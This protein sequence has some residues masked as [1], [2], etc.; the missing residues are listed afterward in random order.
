MLIPAAL[1]CVSSAFAGDTWDGGESDPASFRSPCGNTLTVRPALNYGGTTALYH[2]NASV[3]LTVQSATNMPSVLKVEGGVGHRYNGKAETDF[4]LRTEL[5]AP[6][7]AETTF[8]MAVPYVFESAIYDGNFAFSDESGDSEEE[9]A[10]R[11]S[12]SLFRY[13]VIS[14]HHNSTSTQQ[15]RLYNCAMTIAF[16]GSNTAQRVCRIERENYET[17]MHRRYNP[18]WKHPHS[19]N[20]NDSRRTASYKNDFDINSR[21]LDISKITSW[22]D[23]SVYDMIVAENAD[24]RALPESFRD[25]A[26][27]WVM[28]GGAVSLVGCAET[29]S[30]KLGFGSVRRHGPEIDYTALTD[31]LANSFDR[32]SCVDGVC[33]IWSDGASSA[34]ALNERFSLP[35]GKMILILLAFAV[36]AG[37]LTVLLLARFNKRMWIYWMFPALAVGFSIAVIAVVVA[38]GGIRPKLT[39][40]ASTYVDDKTGKAV[41]VQNDVI[42]APFGTDA[43]IEYPDN[44]VVSCLYGSPNSPSGRICTVDR[45]LYSFT[46]KWLPPRWPVRFRTVHVRRLADMPEVDAAWKSRGEREDGVEAESSLGAVTMPLK[47]S[48]QSHEIIHR[49]VGRDARK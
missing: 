29:S 45:G 12:T 14:L 5:T 33:D 46:G 11:S 28:A 47:C 27:S 31:D 24:W 4:T 34:A 21:I 41:T 3:E 36:A 13:D 2:G 17:A 39:Q 26:E 15:D 38:V 9:H 35:T 48:L 49:I 6:A 37:P 23:L 18:N 44:A 30:E 32:Q 42:I 22:R 8:R 16:V 40:F 43:A 1:L 25:M 10:G 20:K 19:Q 7:A